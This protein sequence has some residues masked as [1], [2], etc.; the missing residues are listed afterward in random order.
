MRLQLGSVPE[1]PDFIPDASWRTLGNR[2]QSVWIWQLKAFPIAIINMGLVALIWTILTPFE[3][4]IRNISFPL[5]IKGFILCLTG[6]LF[7]HELIHVAIHPRVGLTPRSILGFWPSRML[8]Y[9]AY[10]GELTRNRYLVMLLMPFF[11]I[12]IIPIFMAAVAHVLNVWIVY[13]T[14]LNAFLACGDIMIAW[15]VLKIPSN[16]IIR[17]QYWK[18]VGANIHSETR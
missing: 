12:S 4:I 2:E 14:I 8:L 7:V 16:S 10:D 1:S 17:N 13:I 11:V 9:A 3:G 18:P 15:T 6:V 5:P